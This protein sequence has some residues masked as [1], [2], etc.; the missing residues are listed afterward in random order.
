VY[1]TIE[2][3]HAH[4][5][6]EVTVAIQGPDSAGW[7]GGLYAELQAETGDGWTTILHLTGMRNKRNQEF[8]APIAPGR[9]RYELSVGILGPLRF[10]VPQVA[11]GT[12]RFERRYV[13]P[14]PKAEVLHATF[15]VGE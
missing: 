8:P 14:G 7:I 3:D 9:A 12:Y 13:Q 6:D 5:G 4:P 15:V 10:Q 1:I 2:P 11:P